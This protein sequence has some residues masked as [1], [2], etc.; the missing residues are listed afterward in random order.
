MGRVQQ[1][2]TQQTAGQSDAARIKLEQ[3]VRLANERKIEVDHQRE[4]LAKM[5]QEDLRQKRKIQELRNQLAQLA[6][7]N[8]KKNSAA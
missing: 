2:R 1:E 8:A 6:G 5:E 7:Q 4:R 3:A